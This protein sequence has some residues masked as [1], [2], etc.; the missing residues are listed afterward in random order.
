MRDAIS[1]ALVRVL[2]VLPW[3]RRTRPGRHTVRY[4][5]DRAAPG[6]FVICAART[7]LPVHV[8]ARSVPSP[9]GHRVPLYLRDWIREQEERG[10]QYERRAVVAAATP[11]VD[12]P[13]TCDGSDVAR[14]GVSA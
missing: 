14:V 11:G 6:P 8:L 12:L 9:C 3:T 5:T 13:F 2:D 7:P 1:R 10:R 4:L